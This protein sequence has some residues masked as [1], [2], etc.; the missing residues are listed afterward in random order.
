MASRMFTKGHDMLFSKNRPPK[1]P[2]L[3]AQSKEERIDKIDR[4]QQE[5]KQAQIQAQAQAQGQG[6]QASGLLSLGQQKQQ[7][8]GNQQQ[9]EGASKQTKEGAPKQAQGQRKGRQLQLQRAHVS[10]EYQSLVDAFD[11]CPLVISELA[12]PKTADSAR[13]RISAYLRSTRGSSRLAGPE[14]SLPRGSGRMGGG[15]GL[16]GVFAAQQTGGSDGGEETPDEEEEAVPYARLDK[17]SNGNERRVPWEIVKAQGVR[18]DSSPPSPTLDAC[19]PLSR[20][21]PTTPELSPRGLE[22]DRL[23]PGWYTWRRSG[24]VEVPAL[25]PSVSS[26]PDQQPDCLPAALPSWKRG[27]GPK[28]QSLPPAPH[29]SLEDDRP[30]SSH[31]ISHYQRQQQQLQAKQKPGAAP[32][33]RQNI[34]SAQAGSGWAGNGA[35]EW[36]LG[37]ARQANA[38]WMKKEN[39]VEE[40]EEDEPSSPNSPDAY[41]DF[42]GKSSSIHTKL[43]TSTLSGVCKTTSSASNASKQSMSL[44]GAWTVQLLE[45]RAR[46]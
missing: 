21:A 22:G 36:G 38:A 19:T 3:G 11:S 14:W 40:E 16:G 28:A 45:R 8:L 25:S 26:S 33:A 12:R 10:E 4:T 7:G 27:A 30:R 32:T 39:R 29:L 15:S 20:S 2:R 17:P 18:Q 42:L 23:S 41:S 37:S 6:L 1:A 24:T 35:G 5:P 46:K 34:S 9:K 44:N 13:S 31:G 43:Q